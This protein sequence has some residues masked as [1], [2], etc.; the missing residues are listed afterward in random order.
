MA[1][2]IGSEIGPYRVTEYV[3]AGGM[4][5]VYK[6]H[7][8]R[9][10]RSVAIKVMHANFTHDPNFL[11]RFERE[12][13]IV[14]RLEHPNIIPI[15]DYS[16]V[17]GQ[18]YLVMKFVEGQTLKDALRASDGPLP[19]ETTLRLM[20]RIAGAIDYAHGQGVLHRDIKPSNIIIDPRGEPYITDFG[21]ARILQAGASTMSADVM[22]GTPQYISPEQAKG[23]VELDARTD[24]Y[25]LGIVLYEIVTGSVP[26]GGD[27]P[28]AIVHD[29]IYSPPPR[30]RDRNPQITPAV[31][32]VLLRALAKDPA[33]RYPTA[34]ALI[35]EF[36]AA[37]SGKPARGT[38]ARGTPASGTPAARPPEPSPQ[39]SPANHPAGGIP[40]PQPP[41]PALPPM[42]PIFARERG[43]FSERMEDWGKE[44]ERW[45]EN[46]GK[47]AEEWGERFGSQ[48]EKVFEGDEKDD[49]AHLT[50][51]ERI[52]RRV[53]KRLEERQGFYG[54]LTSY[55]FVN[56][57]LWVIY[58]LTRGDAGSHPWPLWVTVFWGM[59]MV[60][61][62]VDYWNKYG[63]GRDRREEMIERELERERARVYGVEKAKHS[64][65]DSGAIGSVRL[66]E[67][68]ELT[69]STIDRL[70]GRQKRKNE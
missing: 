64:P 42:P 2:Q 25:S 55:I 52:R 18:P 8:T 19:I 66:T 43:S 1:V 23:Q 40:A 58:F 24:L 17:D 70:E 5:S 48:V 34:T 59:G 60:G 10:D 37:Q 44:M 63:G 41:P 50:V 29:H 30:P 61:H 33:E 22:L 16:E 13:R 31:D 7:H 35:E 32:E 67:D 3:G 39:P 62:A 12:A 36:A 45:G 14:A 53:E 65:I 51:E 57:M 6:G 9:L 20:R 56:L 4:A 68:G 38:P 54:H 26:F 27:T 15:Y 21:L 46:F 28:Y 47:R 11:A 49:E 69:E